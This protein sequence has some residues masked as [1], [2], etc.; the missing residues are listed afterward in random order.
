M[1]KLKVYAISKKIQDEGEKLLA[2]I[3]NI[4]KELDQY[5]RVLEELEMKQLRIVKQQEMEAKRKAEEERREEEQKRREA[6]IAEA[7]KKQE[8]EQKRAAEEAKKATEEKAKADKKKADTKKAKETEKAKPEAGTP[9][10]KENAPKAEENKESA[11]SAAPAKK[12]AQRPAAAARKNAPP[13]SADE[14]PRKYTGVPKKQDNRGGRGRAPSQSRDRRGPRQDVVESFLKKPPVVPEK[15][16]QSTKPGRSYQE[17][18]KNKDRR[19]TKD[20]W[21]DKDKVFLNKEQRKRSQYNR[22]RSSATT[23]AERKKAITMG[24][25]ISVKDL[26]ERIGIAVNDIIKKLMAM[27]IMA[28]INNELDYDTA[29]IIAD[30]FGIAIE[31]KAVKSYEERLSDEEIHDD[32]TN[33][34]LRPP[35]VTVMGHVDH[36]KTSLLDA[37]RDANVTGQEAGGITQ[38]IGAYTVRHK[39]K[40]ITFIDTPGHEAFTSMRAR[41]AQVTDVAILV[42]AADDGVMPQTVEAI[43]HA[44]A[45]KVPIII[46]INKMD[47]PNANPDRVKQSLS[48]HNVLVEEWGGETIAVPVSAVK[49]TGIDTLLEM[50]SLQAEMLELTANPDTKARGTII[51]AQLDKGRGPV[52]TILVQKGTLRVGDSIVAGT[53]FGRVRAMTDHKGK[54]IEEAGP[55]IPVEIQGLSSVPLAGDVIYAVEDDRL[56]KQVA[57]ERQDNIKI[58]QGKATSRVSLDDLFNHIK[59]GDRVDL[60]IIIKADVQG[61]VEA[62]IQALEKLSNDQVSVQ[63]KH[64][65]VGAISESDVMLATASDALI[66]GFNVRASQNASDLAEREGV[67]IRTYR[68]IYDAIEDVLAAM[69]GL[70]APEFKEVTIGRAEVRAVFKVSGVGT[71]AGCYVTD[72]KIAR[73][74]DITVVRDGVVV[75]TGTIHSLKRFKDDAKE[76]ATGYECGIGIQNFNDIKEGDI[77]EASIRQEVK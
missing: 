24:E 60:N 66:I 49:K 50:I 13:R 18:Q 41:G 44:N 21:D 43:N 8:E 67:D 29:A 73:N 47:L 59:E 17:N 55:S 64:G 39:G 7:Q 33:Q 16:E 42:V 30:D 46:A 77:L 23:A 12:E 70:L 34:L 69:K 37:I 28:T 32:E 6:E 76:V 14:K 71:I 36:G 56:A 4:G 53:A 40:D 61:S 19:H 9:K 22:R 10:P 52:A 1:A 25:S 15:D 75:Y 5:T 26:S 38:H 48:E 63:V 62:V 27:G 2:D 20:K 72:G 54:R 74:A 57:E 51:E 68:V 3:Q 45:A 31:K 65:G 11:K 35:I 58:E